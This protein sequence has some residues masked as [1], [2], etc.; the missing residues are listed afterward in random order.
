M[1]SASW[2]KVLTFFGVWAV[3]WVP[4]ALLI[5]RLINW[6]P[7]EPLA[8]QQKLILLASLYI[9]IPGMVTWKI[10]VEHLSFA[11]LGLTPMSY[12]LRDQLWGLLLSLGSLAS[13]LSIESAL[14]LLDWQWHQAKQLRVL[15]LPIFGL[16]LVISFVEELVFRGYI[17][18]TLSADNSWLIAAIASSFIFAL[19]HLI[20][21]RKQTLPQLP[22]LFLMGM[23][24]I[25][26]RIISNN[27][28][29]LS[30]GL[31]TGWIW[32]L[33]CI[34]SA[35]LITYKH[36]NHWITGINQ[37]PLAGLGGFLCLGITGLALYGLRVS[38]VLST[39]I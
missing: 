32:G 31:H 6:Q 19:L 26:A 3:I 22:G 14:D 36:Q 11:S 8:P 7:S 9:L 30:V 39:I 2:F 5:C 20:W 38:G 34:D 12:L 21:E 23:V 1:L 33:T 29:Y 27:S 25:A 16:S 24:L 15:L 10:N 35:G 37:Q 17:F 18:I 13:V 28:L 4:I